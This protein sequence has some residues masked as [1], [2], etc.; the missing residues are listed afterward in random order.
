MRDKGGDLGP[1]SEADL[2]ANAVLEARL[3][4]DRPGYAWLSEESPDDPASRVSGPAWIVDPLDGTRAFLKGEADWAVAAAM[5]VDG[6][7]EAAVVHLPARGLTYA[8]LRGAGATLDDAPI[9]AR[10]IPADPPAVLTTKANL[11]P[12]DWPDGLPEVRTAFRPSL[13]WRLCLVAEGRFDAML[14]LRDSWYWDIAAG[15]LIAAEAG[16]VVTDRDG[17]PL[18]F[19]GWTPKTAGCVATGGIPHEALIP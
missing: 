19:D 13:A 6:V 15:A 4:D 3:R 9:R 2:A 10:A 18:R 17:A 1:V 5:V 8:A 12:E 14:T 16:A 11:R 7:P